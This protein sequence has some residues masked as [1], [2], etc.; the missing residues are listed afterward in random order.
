MVGGRV[1][2]GLGNFVLFI[3]LSKLF[4]IATVYRNACIGEGKT[5]AGMSFPT[6]VI[7][8]VLSI[9]MHFVGKVA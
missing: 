5:P 4:N 9:L 1:R 3:L 2:C 8:F 6:V 7:H